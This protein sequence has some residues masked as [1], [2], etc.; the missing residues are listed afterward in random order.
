MPES[1]KQLN[2]GPIAGQKSHIDRE[3]SL[4]FSLQTFQPEVFE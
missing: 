1:C 3:F 2:V 4:A